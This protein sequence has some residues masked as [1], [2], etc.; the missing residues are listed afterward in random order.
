MNRS[1]SAATFVCVA[2]FD[3]AV[4]VL[5][6]FQKNTLVNM[7]GVAGLNVEMRISDAA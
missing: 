2:K 6:C 1:S 5:H 4:Y 7:I 3:D